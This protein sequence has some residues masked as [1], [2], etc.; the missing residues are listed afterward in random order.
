MN[1]LEWISLILTATGF[2]ITIVQLSRTKKAVDA[3][4]KATKN[5]LLLLKDRSSI[6]DVSHLING[7]REIQTALRGNRFETALIRIQDLRMKLF[8]LRGKD[9]FKNK[10]KLENI[11]SATFDLKK[12]QDNLEKKIRHIEL[13]IPVP[14]Y[15][16][17]LAELISKMSEWQEEIRYLDRSDAK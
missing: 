6:E 8:E 12:M 9:Y 11:T 13:E 17:T 10:Q 16:M 14:K 2:I 5:T 4:N 7:F 3:T 1:I 15:N